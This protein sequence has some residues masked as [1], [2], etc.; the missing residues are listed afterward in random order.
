MD[1]AQT[2]FEEKLV[3]TAPSYTWTYGHQSVYDSQ[4]I[5]P[6]LVKFDPS[7]LTT[8]DSDDDLKREISEYFANKAELTPDD[9]PFHS[10]RVQ[11]ISSDLAIAVARYKLKRGNVIPLGDHLDI[12]PGHQ[13][14][15]WYYMDPLWVD[16]DGTKIDVT[17]D[18]GMG[19]L[20]LILDDY[21]AN[22][23]DDPSKTKLK[24]FTRHVN[25]LEFRFIQ[26]GRNTHPLGNDSLRAVVNKINNTNV[27]INGMEFKKHHV[28]WVAPEVKTASVGGGG[29]A[30]T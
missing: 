3:Q 1:M 30:E 16:E 10:V 17:T 21:L 29:A 6:V 27:T 28:L 14:Q 7:K 23:D 12:L 24:R 11:V 4:V 2:E 20:A 9:V 5:N 13:S 19:K 26:M 8:S 15:S 25:F 18:S 22:T